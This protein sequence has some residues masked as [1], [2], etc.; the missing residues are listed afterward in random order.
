[1][2]T[3]ETRRANSNA[4]AVSKRGVVALIGHTLD[5]LHKIL[6]CTSPDS[7]FWARDIIRHI[8][9]IR[10]HRK[11]NASLWLSGLVII[12]PQGISSLFTAGKSFKTFNQSFRS[13]GGTVS[14][15]FN[16]CGKVSEEIS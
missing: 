5:L 1:M 10:K 6:V 2:I 9:L 11:N 8:G 14:F 7:F 16:F 12:T 15:Q 3:L 13:L 4:L